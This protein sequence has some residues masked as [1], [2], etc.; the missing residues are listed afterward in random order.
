MLSQKNFINPYGFQ[1]V[2]FNVQN[3]PMNIPAN[4]QPT[5]NIMN[6]NGNQ[7]Y[8]RE[9][10]VPIMYGFPQNVSYNN[11]YYYQN[12]EDQRNNES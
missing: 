11:E 7:F 4:N 5:E 9:A 2:N 8:N 6:N 1:N 10:T 12:I 3:N